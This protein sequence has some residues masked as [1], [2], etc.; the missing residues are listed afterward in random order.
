MLK[1]HV[2]NF[3]HMFFSVFNIEVIVKKR[4]VFYFSRKILSIAIISFTKFIFCYKEFNKSRK[5]LSVIHILDII[6]N[7]RQRENTA[8]GSKTIIHTYIY[9]IRI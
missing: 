1:A 4:R 3:F 8:G 6:D 9:I 7:Y 5:H 2:I